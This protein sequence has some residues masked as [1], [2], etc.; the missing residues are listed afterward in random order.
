MKKIIY[1]IIIQIILGGCNTTPKN[2]QIVDIKIRKLIIE[3]DSIPEYNAYLLDLETSPK[4]YYQSLPLNS[5]TPYTYGLG[6]SIRS[7]V[8]KNVHHKDVTDYFSNPKDSLTNNYYLD[9]NKSQ[10]ALLSQEYNIKDLIKIINRNLLN[11]RTYTN[12]TSSK[13]GHAHI[14]VLFY[15]P[16]SETPNSI[17]ICLKDKEIIGKVYKYPEVCSLK[18]FIESDFIQDNKLHNIEE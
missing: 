13:E 8:I 16:K 18:A 1:F 4:D 15:L 12:Q 7:I 14:Y 5:S 11:Y 2:Y 17:K 10:K 3:N 6:D 9:F